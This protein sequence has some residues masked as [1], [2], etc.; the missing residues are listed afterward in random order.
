MRL[1]IYGDMGEPV[2][3]IGYQFSDADGPTGSRI[4]TGITAPSAGIYAALNATIPAGTVGVT[5]SDDTGDKTA[6]AAIEGALVGA[7]S[8]HETARRLIVEHFTSNWPDTFPVGQENHEL[9]DRDGVYGMLSV[10]Q[11]ET[12]API[13]GRGHERAPGVLFLSVFIKSGY[14]TKAATDAA[15]WMRNHFDGRQFRA[16]TVVVTMRN[17]GMLDAGPRAGYVQKNIVCRF[18][19]DCYPQT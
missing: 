16:G 3:G 6:F 1:D 17:C 7:E 11:A 15:D 12:T 4:T 9:P 14:G 10:Q 8:P 2:S 18:S 19:R 5:W 13:V